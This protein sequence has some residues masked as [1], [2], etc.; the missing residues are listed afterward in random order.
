MCQ[1]QT[2]NVHIRLCVY[3][4]N[5]L[6]FCF[7]LILCLYL[8]TK[9]WSW[10]MNMQMQMHRHSNKHCHCHCH[11]YEQ[12]QRDLRLRCDG[13]LLQSHISWTG[14]SRLK[15]ARTDLLLH[16]RSNDNNLPL[17]SIRILSSVHKYTFIKLDFGIWISEQLIAHLAQLVRAR[18]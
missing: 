4:I 14:D 13:T 16:H 7:W 2:A 18:H 17:L 15:R 10:Q 6:P 11:W 1:I 8:Y 3:D 5:H 12:R 9:A